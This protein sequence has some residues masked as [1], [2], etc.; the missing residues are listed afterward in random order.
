M[1]NVIPELMKEF[2]YFTSDIEDIEEK[3]FLKTAIISHMRESRKD[4]PEEIIRRFVNLQ[5]LTYSA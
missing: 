4:I 2:D 3:D 5:F 1:N